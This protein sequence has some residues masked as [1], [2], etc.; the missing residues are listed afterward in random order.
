[1]RTFDLSGF[2][3]Y[4][5]GRWSFTI[6]GVFLVM[7][8]WMVQ[9]VLLLSADVCVGYYR[10]VDSIW[11]CWKSDVALEISCFLCSV[12]QTV[13]SF[14]RVIFHHVLSNLWKLVL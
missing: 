3:D 14:M 1:M 2:V 4:V 11:R 9:L 13:S 7:I 12:K 6:A 8:L 5:W 10:K